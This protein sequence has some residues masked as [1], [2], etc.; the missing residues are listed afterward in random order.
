MSHNRAYRSSKLEQKKK[1]KRIIKIILAVI[2]SI[3]IIFLLSYYSKHPKVVINN[4]II[5]E[6]EFVDDEL[7][8]KTVE[9][10]LSRKYVWLFAKSN[11]LLVPRDQIKREILETQKSISEI[12]IKV[13]QINNLYIEIVEH[14][15][16][17]K[18][19]GADITK[20]NECYLINEQSLI[21]AKEN[22]INPKI[23][24]IFH[25]T[26][27]M[28]NKIENTVDGSQ[29]TDVINMEYM[30]GEVFKNIL[31]FVKNLNQFE[32]TPTYISTE[33]Y[34]TFAV[35]AMS[36]PYLLIDKRIE[37]NEV[38]SNL[39]TVIEIEEINK[40]QFKNLEY[41]DLRFGNKVY[42]KIK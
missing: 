42:Y 35:R 26:I 20:K 38:L 22:S 32:I 9:E 18:W 27:S 2:L 37:P 25:S 3:S 33:D 13:K 10:I 8:L 30:D 12:S 29:Q 1:K 4:I 14:A 39:Q 7:V 36:G 5:S 21:F 23:V 41:I 11:F 34:E 6:N 40:A 16:V 24:P 31:T 15:P 17:A 19:C 28:E